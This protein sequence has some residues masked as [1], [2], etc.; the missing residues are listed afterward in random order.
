MPHPRPVK[1]KPKVKVYPVLAQC[2]EDGAAY[3]VHR[4]FKYAEHPTE[5][6]ICEHVERE[7]LNLLCERLDLNEHS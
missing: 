6:A 5:D 7:I 4:A 1:P 3:G 2:V